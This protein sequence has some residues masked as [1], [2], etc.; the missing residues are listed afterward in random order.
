MATEVKVPTLG[1]SISSGILASWHVKS[2]DFVRSGQTIYDLETDKITSEGTAECDGV[3]EL[4]ANEGDEVDIGS[5]VAIIDESRTG[6]AAEPPTDRVSDKP[7]Q[8]T[9]ATSAEAKA[10]QTP[11]VAAHAIQTDSQPREAPSVR[12]L[13]DEHEID[14]Q[15]IQGTGKGGRVTKGD[16]LAELAKRKTAATTPQE[17]N[18]SSAERSSR[19]KMSPLRKTIAN[20]LVEAQQTTAM[21]TTFNEVDMSA[22]MAARKSHQETFVAKHGI[23]LGFMSFFVKSVV[24]ALKEWPAVNAQIEGDEIVSNHYYDIG[25]A[26]STPKGLMVPV[27]R[28]CDQLSFADVEQAIVNMAGR[29]RDGK[30]GID[31]L[32]GG[33][34]TVTN[35]GVF[36][37]MLSTPILNTPQSAILGMH[38]IQQRPAVVNG[39]ILARPMMYLALSYDHRIIDGREAVGFLCTIKDCIEDPTRLLFEI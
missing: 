27:I 24:R 5:V 33:V 25:V 29:A 28:D 36:G 30:I 21:L 34:F 39:E 8:D 15:A 12:R 23:K 7:T 26:V 31:D 32:K 2:G 3:I 9:S 38:T 10:P 16:M 11:Q 14:P 4:K 18:K 20:R 37:S 6:E 35:G 1:E 13:S 22:V 19:R 17:M